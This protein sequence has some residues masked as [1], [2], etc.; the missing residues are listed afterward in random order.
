MDIRQLHTEDF[1]Y[2]VPDVHPRLAVIKASAPQRAGLVAAGRVETAV[3]LGQT[4][5]DA[6][7]A[8]DGR[9]REA[10]HARAV[11]A[12]MGRLDAAA[13]NLDRAAALGD[14]ADNAHVAAVGGLAAF[15]LLST[16]AVAADGRRDRAWTDRGQALRQLVGAVENLERV[17]LQRHQAA[18][19]LREA[20]TRS[21]GARATPSSGGPP[22]GPG[23]TR[24]DQTAAQL[25][26]Q[27]VALHA[28][29]DNAEVDCQAKLTAA[30][31][32]LLLV[33]ACVTE[34]ETTM[35]R[36]W[37]RLNQVV[38]E[39]LLGRW[40]R[41][42]PEPGMMAEHRTVLVDLA[43]RVDRDRSRAAAAV[44]AAERQRDEERQRLD[45]LDGPGA[46]PARVLDALSAWLTD[47][48]ATHAATGPEPAPVILDDTF[49]GLDP[50]V[51]ATLVDS[52]AGLSAHT[53]LLYLTDQLDV[54]A[55]AISL[56]HDIGGID[57][58]VTARRP[59]LALT[60]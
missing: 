13:S 24:D 19:T 20:E 7:I 2:S 40:G 35:D 3:V 46:E 12:Q 10:A 37:D 58:V 34:A 4:D 43:N 29:L 33:I 32:E 39:D 54:L 5:A 57:H 45:E 38:G 6:V 25:L 52:L 48:T 31:E 23:A 18:A 50:P 53:Q 27:I 15:D 59:A 42:H 28:A 60:E 41:G 36:I 22:P 51:R 30:Q 8:A 21:R 14:E 55:W 44:V 11:A 17:Q 9:R 56:P 47:V 49:V 26:S 16:D 1:G